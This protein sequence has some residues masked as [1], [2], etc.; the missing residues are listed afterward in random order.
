MPPNKEEQSSDPTFE[1]AKKRAMAQ[2]AME[3]EERRKRR[4]I[5]E[6]L[7][8]E[9]E[10]AA[11]R[12]ANEA[13]RAQADAV[14]IEADRLARIKEMRE[15]R[16]QRAS[17]ERRVLEEVRESPT[18][19]LSPIRTLKFDMNR[20]V[21]ETKASLVS[22]AIKEDEK[23][24]MAETGVLREKSKSRV[25]L[26]LSI[27]CICGGAGVLAW[28]G[29]NAYSKKR[30]ETVP[31]AAPRVDSL[32]FSEKYSDLVVNDE[33]PVSL[34]QKLKKEVAGGNI[35]I[36]TIQYMR[37]VDNSSGMLRA[38]SANELL[39]KLNLAT[40]DPLVRVLEDAFMYGIFS[41]AENSGFLVLKTSYYERAFAGMLS[42][43][44]SLT[45]DLYAVLSGKTL[46]RELQNTR[47]TDVTIK[48]MDARILRDPD[49]KTALVYAFFPD[50]TT[51][52][53]A[54]TEAALVEILTRITTP[55]PQTV[56]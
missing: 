12:K 16:K 51:I 53:I 56:Q 20:A 44:G 29:Y 17:E 6:K 37:M 3:G 7:R 52:V 9:R 27:L 10:L 49:G 47:F 15:E 48:N 42:W 26:V 13:T 31:N 33:T 11:A 45:R 28:W 36:G 39:T 32:V 19:S 50:K 22:M 18:I 8:K 43:E 35:P 5:E 4:E 14:K 38:I 21:K 23:R 1:L 54:H 40:P 41:S 34:A 30:I 46:T 55:K 24:K 2:L 25:V